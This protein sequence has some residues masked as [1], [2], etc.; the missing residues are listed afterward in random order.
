MQDTAGRILRQMRIEI[1]Q[2]ERRVTD[3][4][5]RRMPSRDRLKGAE[6]AAG[7]EACV[8]TLA[9]FCNR[10]ALAVLRKL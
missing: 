8:P 7:D 1:H 6:E 4:S 10:L 2:S 5:A 3:Q 9:Q